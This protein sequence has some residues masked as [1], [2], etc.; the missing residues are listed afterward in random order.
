MSFHDPLELVHDI[1]VEEAPRTL[2]ITG[3]ALDAHLPV[4]VRLAVFM[5]DR[6]DRAGCSTGSR[7]PCRV[8]G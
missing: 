2:G 5:G 1:E 7:T 4:H 8:P 6:P 3:T